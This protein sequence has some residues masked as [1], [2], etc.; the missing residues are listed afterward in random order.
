MAP[1]DDELCFRI[2]VSLGIFAH[3]VKPCLFLFLKKLTKSPIEIIVKTDVT[4]FKESKA[5]RISSNMQPK[6]I[7][8]EI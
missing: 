1:Q 5:L 6:A 4:K 7:D 8:E 3:L 2:F